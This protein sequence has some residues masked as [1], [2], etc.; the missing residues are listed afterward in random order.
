M[1]KLTLGYE[2]V[3][4]VGDSLL[5]RF[6][7]TVTSITPQKVIL[8]GGATGDAGK[9][10]MIGDTYLF[11]T[12]SRCW[13]K[14]TPTGILPS[15]RAAHAATAIESQQMVIYGGAT[16]G[17]TNHKYRRHFGIRRFIPVRLKTRR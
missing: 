17:K 9:F 2:I 11:T 15:Q 5:P 13:V 3:E 4:T 12:S 10:T 16:G 1:S 7:H 14:L 8:F 6:G